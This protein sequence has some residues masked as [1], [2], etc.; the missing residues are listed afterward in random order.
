MRQGVTSGS[1][2]WLN[3]LAEAAAGKT[4]TA[5]N[6]GGRPEHAWFTGFIPYRDPNLVLTIL[7]EEGGEGSSVAVPLA[8]EIF[9]WWLMNG[10]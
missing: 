4:G 6:I 8:K 5:Q 1:A 2:R 9:S 10:D 7:I 3:D